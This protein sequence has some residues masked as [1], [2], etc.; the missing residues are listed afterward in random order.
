MA[1]RTPA[2]PAAHKRAASKKPDGAAKAPVAARQ[3]SDEEIRAR[4][5]ERY[6]ERGGEPGGDFDDWLEAE[7][8]LKATRS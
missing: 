7:K 4:A 8:D 5:Y 3:P 2:S 1:K 6:L